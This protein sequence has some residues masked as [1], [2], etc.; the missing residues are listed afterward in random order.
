M[1]WHTVPDSEQQPFFGY[2]AVVRLSDGT[3]ERHECVLASDRVL[4]VTAGRDLTDI[5][6]LGH[7][8][9]TRLLRHACT[10][11]DGQVMLAL[12]VERFVEAAN[13]NVVR[14][15]VGQH[16]AAGRRMAVLASWPDQYTMAPGLSDALGAW[17]RMGCA[18]GLDNFGFAPVPALWPYILRLDLVR[19]DARLMEMQAAGV[20]RQ[21]MVANLLE[22]VHLSGVGEVIADGCDSDDQVWLARS[23]GATHAQGR[24]FGD[25]RLGRPRS[26]LDQIS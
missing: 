21:D 1:T 24:K 3:A 15:L 2:R 6:G 11:S 7:A 16:L 5:P 13:D 8:N 10:D 20:I 12:P 9:H 19:I 4:S 23:F 14:R 25:V 17:R 26:W 22:F 18:V